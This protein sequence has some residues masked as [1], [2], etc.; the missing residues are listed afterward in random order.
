MFSHAY[1]YY[2]LL[3][4]FFSYIMLRGADTFKGTSQIIP[5]IYQVIGGVCG[6]ATIPFLILGFWF[7]PH[8][9]YPIVFFL[10]EFVAAAIPL[11]ATIASMIGIVAAPAFT[12]LMYLSLFGIL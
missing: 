1:L 2:F 3:A 5:L 8:W 10:L 11:P 6:F 12:V 4:S 7:M 9:W